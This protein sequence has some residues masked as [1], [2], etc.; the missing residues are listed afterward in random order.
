MRSTDTSAV[1]KLRAIENPRDILVGD[2]ILLE[3]LQGARDERHA[4]TISSNMSA[5][6][7]EPMLSV[8]LAEKTARNFRQLRAA[9]ITTRKTSDLIIGTYCIEF[10]H[11]LLHEDRDFEPMVRHLDLKTL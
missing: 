2:I 10:G 8:D 9:G 5:Y 6:L 1:A 7:Q 3:L 4:K 11:H